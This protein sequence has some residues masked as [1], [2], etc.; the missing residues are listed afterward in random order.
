M[1]R[2]TNYYSHDLRNLL[3]QWNNLYNHATLPGGYDYID[4]V[5]E[6]I[7][8]S[9]KKKNFHENIFSISQYGNKV[10]KFLGNYSNANTGIK[11]S[12]MF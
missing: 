11:C 2:R 9:S 8:D 10:R 7:Y 12:E 6:Y 5:Y 4:K 3:P 1:Q